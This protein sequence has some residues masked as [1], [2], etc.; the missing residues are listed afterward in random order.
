MPKY[1][2]PEHKTDSVCAELCCDL[3]QGLNFLNNVG[4]VVILE[5]VQINLQVK[6]QQLQKTMDRVYLPHSRC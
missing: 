1:S 3:F 4:K 6:L 2:D 5:A